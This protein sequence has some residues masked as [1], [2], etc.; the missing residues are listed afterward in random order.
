MRY[1]LQTL[2]PLATTLGLTKIFGLTTIRRP[3][4]S[5]FLMMALQSTAI[6]EPLN[7]GEGLSIDRP[8]DSAIF[9]EP[10]PSFNANK[11]MLQRRNEGKIQYFVSIDRLG[12]NSTSAERYFERLLRDIGDASETDSLKIIDQG[13]Y[14]TAANV[15]GSYV[16]F[17]FTP[18]G[19]KRP[20]HQVA[21]FLTNTYRNYIAIAVL[22]DNAAEPQLRDDTIALFNSASISTLNAP[23]PS[24]LPVS[25]AK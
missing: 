13:D 3:A 12:R 17:V 9:F 5:V 24:S 6:A 19:S 22:V 11:K 15:R 23:T 1:K 4:M 7:L 20:Q 2:R 8:T 16:D 21:H 18:T 14:W 10:I 25:V